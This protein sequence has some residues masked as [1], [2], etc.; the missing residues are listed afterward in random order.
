MESAMSNLSRPHTRERRP[1][2]GRRLATAIGLVV[3]VSLAMEGVAGASH[4]PGDGPRIYGVGSG[5]NQFLIA[6]G[7][8]RLSVAAHLDRLGRPNGHV[9]AQGEP[10]G[11][12]PFESFTLEGEVTCIHVEGNKAAIKYRFKHAEGSAEPFQGGGVQIFLEDNGDPRNGIAV[13]RTTFDPPQM[14]ATFNPAAT[15]CDDPRLRTT[16]DQIE[17]GNFVVHS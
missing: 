4:G 1:H 11:P 13:D 6:I 10:D 14:A 12:G 15:V 3:S 16:Y 8:A 2:V 17:S 7:Q 5:E 9:R